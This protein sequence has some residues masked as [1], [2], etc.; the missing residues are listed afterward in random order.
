[1]SEDWKI[2]NTEDSAVEVKGIRRK[3]QLKKAPDAPKR[4]KSA[5]IC[6]VMEKME[7][8]KKMVP[9]DTKITD[10]MKVL[11]V[12]WRDLPAHERSHYER[13]AENDKNRFEIMF[14]VFIC[15]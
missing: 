4:F 9:P 6:Y 2:D 10:T 1:M 15:S 5:Y 11:A 7:D 8:A 12:M 14:V 13:I 3:K